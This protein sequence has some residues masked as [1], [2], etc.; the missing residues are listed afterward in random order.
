MIA[1]LILIAIQVGALLDANL[2]ISLLDLQ[3]REIATTEIRAGQ[4][5]AYF[6][7]STIYSGTYLIRVATAGSI[8]IK[9]VQVK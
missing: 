3:G 4:T 1:R 8:I 6:D 9:T 5:I 7:V 2:P